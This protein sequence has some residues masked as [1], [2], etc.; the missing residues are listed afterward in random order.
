MT[1]RFP[2]PGCDGE[3]QEAPW[4]VLVAGVSA[5][6]CCP[7]VTG[8]QCRGRESPGQSSLPALE[9]LA[10]TQ[11]SPEHPRSRG[12]P[13]SSPAA[14]AGALCPS[15]WHCG[16]A[17]WAVIP[18]MSCRDG[19]SWMSCRGGCWWRRCPTFASP[20]ELLVPGK[21]WNGASPAPGD[22]LIAQDG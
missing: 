9:A 7:A 18:W 15:Y 14:T 2:A 8:Q 5:C 16:L 20:D 3:G 17:L 19:C 13:G 22:P 4:A 1:S 21:R 12:H 6:P 11:P 10:A